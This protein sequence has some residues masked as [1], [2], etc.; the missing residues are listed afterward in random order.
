MK[1]PIKKTHPH[2]FFATFN[3][4]LEVTGQNPCYES[5]PVIVLQIAIVPLSKVFIAEIVFT[6]SQF[7]TYDNGICKFKSHHK[8][9]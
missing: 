6:N 5:K 7:T 3:S 2:S 9:L 8:H 4:L 1:N